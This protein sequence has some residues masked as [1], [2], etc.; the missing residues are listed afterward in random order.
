MVHSVAVE[1]AKPLEIDGA[2]KPDMGILTL[3]P[4]NFNKQASINDP[5][6]IQNLAKRMQ[7]RGIS[8]ELE[9]FTGGMINY[10]RYLAGKGLLEPQATCKLVGANLPTAIQQ[11]ETRIDKFLADW[12]TQIL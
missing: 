4:V 7:E 12:H 9:A 2:L 3:S 10:A 8:P 6:M 1:Q 5:N 11:P